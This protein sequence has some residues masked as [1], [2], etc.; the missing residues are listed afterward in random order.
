MK[1]R[2]LCLL[3]DGFEEIETI[4]PVDVL[5]RAGAEV[6]LASLGESTM[7]TGRCGVKVQADT[8][9]DDVSDEPFDGLLIPGG[10]GVAAF[11]E[12]R[13]RGETCQAI[14]V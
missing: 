4:T 11:A 12:R 10:P 3:I 6:T 9:L 5:R 14:R 2:V 7:V 1:P 8:L 13:A